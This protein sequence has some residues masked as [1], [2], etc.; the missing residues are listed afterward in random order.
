MEKDFD[1]IADLRLQMQALEKMTDRADAGLTRSPPKALQGRW[2]DTPMNSLA[3]NS[4]KR[5]A[6]S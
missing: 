6:L 1:E 2:H 5:T 4:D 3:R